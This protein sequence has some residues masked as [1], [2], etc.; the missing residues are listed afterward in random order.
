MDIKYFHVAAL[1]ATGLFVI[2]FI[3]DPFFRWKKSEYTVV[4]IVSL[5][6]IY[7]SYFILKKK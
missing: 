5:V 3:T 1:F 6:V 7:G 2:F 4:Y